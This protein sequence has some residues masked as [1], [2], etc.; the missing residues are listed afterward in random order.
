[1]DISH[2]LFSLTF[3]GKMMALMNILRKTRETTQDKV[4]VCSVSFNWRSSSQRNTFTPCLLLTNRFRIM[5][6]PRRTS[7]LLSTSSKELVANLVT[8]SFVSMERLK[9]QIE[10]ISSTLCKLQLSFRLNELTTINGSTYTMALPYSFHFS[11]TSQQSNHLV[12]LGSSET[13]LFE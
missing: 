1:M 7:L 3:P 5:F 8:A 12:S 13:I 6:P 11:A 2:S 4:V 10:W 9:R